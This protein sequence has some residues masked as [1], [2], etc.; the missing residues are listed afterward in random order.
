MT[1][2][3]KIKSVY[4]R[5]LIYPI[6]DTAKIFAELMD[7]KTFTKSQLLIIKKL[8]AEIKVSEPDPFS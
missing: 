4:G 7:R 8:G 6:N 1:V 5:E 3:I 2:E